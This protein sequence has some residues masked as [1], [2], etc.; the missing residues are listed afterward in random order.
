MDVNKLTPETL[1]YLNTFHDWIGEQMRDAHK[2]YMTS[3]SKLGINDP[4]T[5]YYKAKEAAYEHIS[6]ELCC[7]LYPLESEISESVPDPVSTK[8]VH[9]SFTGHRGPKWL[10]WIL[11]PLCKTKW[12]F[13]LCYK[14]G[15]AHEDIDFPVSGYKDVCLFCNSSCPE[16]H[17]CYWNPGE[18][19]YEDP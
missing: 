5:I 2:G 17:S 3:L 13:W 18:N 6:L 8:T 15:L 11:T 4:I 9:V 16:F 12:G 1:E 7:R 10:D 14:L 19:R